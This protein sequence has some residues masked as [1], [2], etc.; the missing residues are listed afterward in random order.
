M[1]DWATI[2][3]G[4]LTL[5]QAFTGAPQAAWFDQQRPTVVTCI[6]LLQHV[7][8]NAYSSGIDSTYQPLPL[9]TPPGGQ[10][11]PGIVLPGTVA[12]TNGQAGIVLSNAPDPSVLIEKDGGLLTFDAQPGISYALA[13]DIS[14]AGAATLA[15]PF[16]GPT[17]A[18]AVA[19]FT[20]DLLHE[21]LEEADYFTIRVRIEAYDQR[22]AKTARQYLENMRTKWWR[23]RT[24][25]ALAALGVGYVDMG[26]TQDLSETRDAHRVSIAS[27][28]LTFLALTTDIDP[29][30][31]PPINSMDTP[32]AN[33]S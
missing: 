17:T 20:S 2:E 3:P 9:V 18:A 23:T 24:T 14:G 22:V 32:T 21:T 27:A 6:A 15:A 19:T 1:I 7:S 33:L 29:L 31:D 12:L 28:D 30:G 10:P 11:T 13:A 5:V 25:I 4:L 26:G 8:T 16:T